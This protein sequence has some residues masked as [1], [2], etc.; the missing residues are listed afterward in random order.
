MN[1]TPGRVD[2]T[3]LTTELQPS[4][5]PPLSP[6]VALQERVAAHFG[7]T[8]EQLLSRDRS[9]SV[10]WARGLACLLARNELGMSFPELGRAF[11]RDQSSVNYAIRATYRRLQRPQCRAL[12]RAYLELRRRD[13][14]CCPPG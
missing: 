5:P 12:Y 13:A 4:S 14:P 8:R 1:P 6:V 7:F 9:R 10:S 2:A 3:V 11:A